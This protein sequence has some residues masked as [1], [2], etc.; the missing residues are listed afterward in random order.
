MCYDYQCPRRENI[1]QL[2]N[3]LLAVNKSKR[4]AGKNKKSE[5]FFLIDNG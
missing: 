5:M 1:M 3:G 2:Y 4:S